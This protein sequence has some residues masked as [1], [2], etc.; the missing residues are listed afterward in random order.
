MSQPFLFSWQIC[1]AL[2]VYHFALRGVRGQLRHPLHLYSQFSTEI[3]DK[4]FKDD[5]TVLSCT[6]LTGLHRQ[7][8][9]EESSVKLQCYGSNGRAAESG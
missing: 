9:S 7:M 1:C 2:R 6:P 5:L 8:G 3:V 4:R